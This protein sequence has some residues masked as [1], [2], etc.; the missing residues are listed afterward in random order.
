MLQCGFDR[1]DDTVEGISQCFENLVAGNGETARYPLC[2]IAALDLHLAHFG[3][4]KSGSNFLLDQF[5]S[6]LADQHPVVTA[7]II[8]DG[9]VKLVTAYSDRVRINDTPEGNHPDL[10]GSAADIHHHRASGLF[11][12]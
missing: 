7:N 9:L 3:S 5:R 4:R 10:G 12:G 11:H 6:N 1:T 2:K 8:D